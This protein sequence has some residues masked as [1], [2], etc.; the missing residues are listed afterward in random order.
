MTPGA[1]VALE[2]TPSHESQN[3]RNSNTIVTLLSYQLDT[4]RLYSMV[5]GEFPIEGVRPD[6]ILIV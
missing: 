6:R 5:R 2:N 4:Y 1:P 3:S